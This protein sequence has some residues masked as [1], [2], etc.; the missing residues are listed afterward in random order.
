M[1]V[2]WNLEFMCKPI[3][4]IN[5][6][7]LQNWGNSTSLGY[8]VWKMHLQNSYKSLRVT[9]SLGNV[10]KMQYAY[11]IYPAATMRCLQKG[12]WYQSTVTQA[13]PSTARHKIV[14]SCGLSH[15]VTLHMLAAKMWGFQKVRGK[16]WETRLEQEK[17]NYL[18]VF[19]SERLFLGLAS[20]FP[21]EVWDCCKYS[22]FPNFPGGARR[23]T[24][25]SGFLLEIEEVV[26]LLVAL[27]YSK[28]WL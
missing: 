24:R 19:C 1:H 6:T 26:F 14:Q 13:L 9:K 21:A 5:T 12:I 7:T 16:L 4:L 22:V 15:N 2:L 8:T 17:V 27:I 10:I 18:F 3:T 20:L 25:M 11:I 28:L 23:K